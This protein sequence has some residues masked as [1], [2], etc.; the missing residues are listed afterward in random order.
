MAMGV[1]S[2]LFGSSSDIEKEL[3]ALYVPMFQTIQGM[4]LTQARSTFRDLL[5][6]AKDAS[7]KEGTSKFPQN[8]GDVILKEEHTNPHYKIMLAKKRNQDVRDEDMRWW[9]NMHDLER[10]MMTEHD[11][12]CGFTLFLK[13]TQEDGL[14]SNEAGNQVK[15]S[16][17]IFGDPDDTSVSAGEDRPLPHELMGR[18]DAYILERSQADSEAFKNEID[19]ASSF[20]ALIRKKIKN[21]E[22]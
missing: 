13:L 14:S 11:N 5:K 10:R 17:P 6:M 12:W 16:S 3:E 9:W 7:L 2:K 21:G 1:F 4:T 20:N 18:I 8:F 15:K 22:V 19:E